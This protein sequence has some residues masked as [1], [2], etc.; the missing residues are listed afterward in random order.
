MKR[1]IIISIIFILLFTGCDASSVPEPLGLPFS[2]DD[3]ISLDAY[4]YQKN[5]MDSGRKKSVTK[6]ESIHAVYSALYSLNTFSGDTSAAEYAPRFA[7]AISAYRFHL[8]DGTVYEIIYEEFENN[9][10]IVTSQDRNPYFTSADISNLWFSLAEDATGC[11]A[12]ELPVPYREDSVLETTA[13]KVYIGEETAVH[14]LVMD[15]FSVKH[16]DFL[17]DEDHSPTEYFVPELRDTLDQQLY[18][19]VFRFE[20]LVCSSIRDRVLWEKFHANVNAIELSGDTASVSAFELYEYELS[21]ANGVES[22]RGTSFTISCQKIDGEW[23]ITEIETDNEL[24]EGIVDGVSAEE[25]PAL[26]GISE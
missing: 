16:Q 14:Q 10:G 7:Y 22:S 13:P 20:K 1:I 21:N 6:S 26:A 3:V 4:Y 11:P 5:F 18:M 23:Y 9:Y 2:S 15:F 8:T 19:K 24:V 17:S 12:V 25:L